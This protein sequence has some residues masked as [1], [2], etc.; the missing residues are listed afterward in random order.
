MGQAQ[1]N[2]PTPHMEVMQTSPFRARTHANGD[3]HTLTLPDATMEER[4]STGSAAHAATIAPQGS[5]TPIPPMPG[6]QLTRGNGNSTTNT[7]ETPATGPTR[8]NPPLGQAPTPTWDPSHR[9][10]GSDVWPPP[11]RQVC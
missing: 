1:P 8:Q 5:H 6:I 3:R 7:E 10:S 9:S 11:P 4:P 2:T